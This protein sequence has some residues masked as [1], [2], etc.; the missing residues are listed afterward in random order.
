MAEDPDVGGGS[1]DSNRIKT[2]KR[3]PHMSNWNKRIDY[4]TLDAR[5]ALYNWDKH[6]LMLLVEANNLTLD[7]LAQWHVV[8]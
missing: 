1:R 3:L 4:Q 5:K 6:S 2:I 8:V 7:N